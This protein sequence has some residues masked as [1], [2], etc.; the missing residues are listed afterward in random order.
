MGRDCAEPQVGVNGVRLDF[1]QS[2]HV[3]ENVNTG[4]RELQGQDIRMREMSS[5]F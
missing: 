1:L 3:D 2:C 4:C 5:L